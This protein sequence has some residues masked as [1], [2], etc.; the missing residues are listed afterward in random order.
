M[1]LCVSVMFSFIVET[2]NRHLSSN[3]CL[4]YFRKALNR[5]EVL[6]ASLDSSLTFNNINITLM[7]TYSMLIQFS[8]GVEVVRL[9][10]VRAYTRWRNG[11]QVKVRSHYRRY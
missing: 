11:K 4:F 10:R 7:R 8:I 3:G 2:D 9:V 6:N 5:G 1:Y